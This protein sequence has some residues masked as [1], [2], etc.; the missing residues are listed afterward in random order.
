MR[1]R[2]HRTT[3]QQL[4]VVAGYAWNR[5]Q[6]SA[7]VYLACGTMPS[8]L[9]RYAGRA[10]LVFAS[11]KEKRVFA[12]RVAEIRITE[13]HPLIASPLPSGIVCVAPRL[14]AQ[15]THSGWTACGLMR[16]ILVQE[17][18]DV[19]EPPPP[20]REGPTMRGA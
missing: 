6:L 13:H 3:Q 7:Q 12:R 17:F 20:T 2:R 5:G 14:L 8:G 11:M 9:L 16:H 10:E 18:L 19:S 4:A 1:S 15:V